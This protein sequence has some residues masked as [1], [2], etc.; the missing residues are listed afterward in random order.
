[1]TAI[2]AARSILTKPF[3]G[4][5]GSLV[6]FSIIWITAIFA[7]FS[8]LTK[9]FPGRLGLDF[10]F[11]STVFSMTLEWGTIFHYIS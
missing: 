1:M 3:P 9:R 5:L 6:Q 2:F 4:R 11:D 8:I 10:P 7:A